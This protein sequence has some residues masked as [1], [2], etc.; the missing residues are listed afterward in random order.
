MVL[1]GIYTTIMD[2]VFGDVGSVHYTIES[3]FF[4]AWA[5]CIINSLEVATAKTINKG[6]ILLAFYKGENGSFLMSFFELFGLHVK[7]LCIID[8]D[9]ALY[10]KKDKDT[11]Q[12]KD[13]NHI[14][15]NNEN[16]VIV[17][18][19]VKCNLKFS[20]AMRNCAT[21]RA[22]N[23]GFRI[24]CIKSVENLLGMLGEEWK[25][26]SFFHQMPSRYLRKCLKNE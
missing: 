6:N 7:S 8:G 17:D 14:F 11:F 16:Y 13:S 4:F 1:Y 22:D 9:N 2:I 23:L 19:G 10:L 25:P 20:N 15:K 18:T 12:F 5:V 3:M 24:C 21:L 26:T